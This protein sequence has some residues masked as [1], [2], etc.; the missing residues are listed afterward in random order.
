MMDRKFNH[1]D[2]RF[3]I[4]IMEKHVYKDT[5]R[6]FSQS[7]PVEFVELEMIVL[8]RFFCGENVSSAE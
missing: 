1:S 5:P 7:W 8:A 2:C 6:S 3:E 4:R